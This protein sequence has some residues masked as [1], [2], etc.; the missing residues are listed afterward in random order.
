MANF[1]SRSTRKSFHRNRLLSTLRALGSLQFFLEHS[2]EWFLFTIKIF[3]TVANLQRFRQEHFG[4]S[5]K[6]YTVLSGNKMLHSLVF[7]DSYPSS[8][9]VISRTWPIKVPL[10]DISGYTENFACLRCEQ[11]C[12]NKKLVMKNFQI[13]CKHQIPF[14]IVVWTGLNVKTWFVLLL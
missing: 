14:L 4:G 5:Q 1:C 3:S 13:F 8:G 9:H 6:A 12:N 2:H 10:I 11:G 7:L